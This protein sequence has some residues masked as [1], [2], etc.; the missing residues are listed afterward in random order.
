MTFGR[1]KMQYVFDGIVIV[2][3]VLFT[4]IGARKGFIK[5]AADLLGG[6]IAMIAAGMLSNPV[7]EFIYT[8]LFAEAVESRIK[9]VLEVKGLELSEYFAQLPEFVSRWLDFAGINADTVAQ[10]MAESGG[11]AAETVTTTLAPI[12]VGLINVFVV[13]ILFLLFMIIIK[14]LANLL[15]GF[16]HLPL[17][18]EVNG[19]LG[20]VLG[21]L[22][23]LL[24]VW[25]AIGAI[26]FFQPMME[27]D[28]LD[29]LNTLVEN[30]TVCDILVRM[31]PI[32][33]MFE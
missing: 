26:E 3:L 23:G 13:I 31:N 1:Y 24:M 32:K 27:H 29:K 9:A 18:K 21:I 30:S 19:L 7:A 17:L 25:V 6:I 5:A 20:A 11:S 33:W 28:T 22:L 4:V 14:A 10:K 2:V 12:F 8:K 16:F 15:T